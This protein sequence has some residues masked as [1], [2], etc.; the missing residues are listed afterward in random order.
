MLQLTRAGKRFGHKLLFEKIDW[1]ITPGERTGLVGGNGT[2]KSTLLRILAGLDSLDDG[3][4]ESTGGMTFGYLPQDGLQLR[5]RSV[6]D[7]CLSAFA[8]TQ[9]LEHKIQH[10]HTQLAE[11]PPHSGEYAA[12]I[13]QL[14]R[15]DAEFHALDGYTIEARVG[16]VLS[17]LGFSKE[18]WQRKTEEFSGGWQMR[19]ALAKLL[20]EKPDLLLLDEPTNHL[21]LEARN[22]LEG[23][24]HAY[25]HAYVLVSHD[26]F[27]LDI[28]TDKIVELWNHRLYSY[29][30][31]YEKYL[32]Q[33]AERQVQLEAA[34]RHQREHI[35]HLESFITRFRAQATKARQV[36]SRVK[37]LERIERIELPPAETEIH[38]TFPQPPPSGRTVAEAQ[39]ISKSYGA[40]EVFSGVQFTIERGERI[41]LVGPNGAGKSTLIRLLAA[42]DEPTTGQL[43][44]GH[45]VVLQYFAQDQYKELDADA[46]MLDDIGRSAPRIPANRIAKPAGMLSIFRRRCLQA[47]RRAFRRR[48]Q[49]LRPGAPAGQS[50]KFSSCWMS[51]QTTSTCAPKKFCW[52]RSETSPG[53]SCLSRTIAPS[54]MRWPRA[55]LKFAMAPCMSTPGTTKT[56]CGRFPARPEAAK[57]SAIPEIKKS[58]ENIA[59]AASPE[60][61]PNGQPADP[62]AAKR[63]SRI[64]PIRLRQMQDRCTA[65]EE[66]IP[67]IEAAIQ[68][69][70]EQLAVYVSRRTLPVAAE[71]TRPDAR[72]TCRHADRMGRIGRATGRTSSNFFVHLLGNCPLAPA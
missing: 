20:L 48:T 21:D 10:L 66:E 1:Q 12:V 42:M 6:F 15:S 23:Y 11:L 13:E 4:M 3:S 57:N 40:K 56:I 35:E 43:R 14:T 22:W 47:A 18:D 69:T 72:R 24:L 61:S 71:S 31:N 68:T 37:E 25:P 39:Q 52:K 46:R 19:I 65:L 2:G 60:P 50:G 34:Y 55:S 7:E 33:K 54:S 45:N 58:N 30:G 5:G 44:L 53:P 27:F 59:P 49:P 28:A 62:T 41:A 32:Q 70:E 51:P 26:R 67:R 9:A 64:N 17:G 8:S 29:T 63:V 36:Q 16:T 38:F